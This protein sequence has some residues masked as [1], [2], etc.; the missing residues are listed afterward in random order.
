MFPKN[1]PVSIN[2]LGCCVSRDVFNIDSGLTY[3][4]KGYVQR[5]CPLDIFD[6]I[7]PE[8][9]IEESFVQDIVDHNFNRRNLCTL[10]N[11]VGSKKLI[12]NKGDWIIL[13]TFYAGCG[14]FKIILPDGYSKVVQ[15]DWG[16]LLQKLSLKMNGIFKLESI[17]GHEN[18]LL[19]ID[20]FVS[21]IKDNWGTNVIL[22]DLPRTNKYLAIDGSI[23]T[24]LSS[25]IESI[26]AADEFT[27]LLLE[28]L[29]CYFVRMPHPLY[30]DEYNAYNVQQV[31]YIKESYQYLKE[32]V[33]TIIIGVDISK[34]L[35]LLFI[36][37]SQI[38][39]E[40]A[41]GLRFSERNTIQRIKN[42]ISSRDS[43]RYP[44]AFNLC[45]QLVIQGSVD[46]LYILS[47]M[48]RDGI[49]VPK[50]IDFAIN[51]IRK[52]YSQHQDYGNALID[53]LMLKNDNSSLIEI[54]TISNNLLSSGNS[55]VFVR[56]ARMYRDG[57]GV[58]K[59]MGKSIN[60]YNKAKS[61][62]LRWSVELFDTL[63]FLHFPKYD[64]LL[65]DAIFE[66]S[67]KNNPDAMMR[68][69]RMYRDGRGTEQNLVLAKKYMADA[70]SINPKY[71]SEY[72]DFMKGV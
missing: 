61:Q 13:D 28:R 34:K 66:L 22:L 46:A 59:D 31:H 18:F 24:R 25:H 2:I 45:N 55:G 9:M 65:K 67:E 71:T 56:L 43:S 3:Q 47:N 40:I 33:D 63:W 48:Y 37:Y 14:C 68:L 16:S 15:T 51:L 8:Y 35:D 57:K 30:G 53:L 58:K 11:G 62:D 4:V 42:I 70:V 72:E 52:A 50:D 5:N 60:Y 27:K 29:D 19:K 1:D 6:I 23:Q 36:K 26:N 64:L 32:A 10:F 20:K 39:H 44:I 69:G 41:M 21:F 49:G 38:F 7:P 12:D 17:E 54:K